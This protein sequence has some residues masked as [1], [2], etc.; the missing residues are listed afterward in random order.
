MPPKAKVHKLLGDRYFL[1]RSSQDADIVVPNP[2]VSKKHLSLTRDSKRPRKFIIR[3]EHST[4]GIY[5]GRK[6][7]K[8]MVLRHGDILTL[9]PP[10]LKDGV[11]V[12]FHNPPT[13]DH[14]DFTLSPLRLRGG[15]GFIC[16]LDCHR[17]V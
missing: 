9:G 2:V 7:L 17:L 14:F 15:I 4:N 12:Q 16:S 3:D 10:E 8:S 6:R 13:P 5:L 11:R 1:G